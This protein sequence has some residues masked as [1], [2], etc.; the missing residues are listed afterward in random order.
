MSH[1]VPDTP[2]LPASRFVST[3]IAHG[4]NKNNHDSHL[5]PVVNRSL[6]RSLYPLRVRSVEHVAPFA[7]S[8]LL[9]TC[10]FIPASGDKRKR[11]DTHTNA[12]QY[13]LCAHTPPLYASSTTHDTSLHRSS[14]RRT[15][16]SPAGPPDYVTAYKNSR[17]LRPLIS[18]VS[19]ASGSVYPSS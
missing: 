13:A 12:P 15:T 10:S 5:P 3:T 9:Q 4:W 6:R 16:R 11:Y 1:V 7:T 18:R 2:P 19:C 14:H 17:K 8:R